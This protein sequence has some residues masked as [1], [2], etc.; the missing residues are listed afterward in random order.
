VQPRCNCGA[1][2][3]EDARFCHKCGKPQYAEDIARLGAH[4]LPPVPPPIAAANPSRIGFGNIRAVGITIAVAACSL[5][6]LW[7]ACVVAPL[8]V[9]IILCGA[10]F[11][12][13]RFYRRRLGEP[14]TPFNGATLGV[15]TGLWLFLMIALLVAITSV[16]IASPESREL[17]K[18]LATKVPD[19]GKMLDDPHQFVVA[20]AEGLIP[21]FFI[22]TIS[23]A[24]GGMLAARLQPR[25]GQSS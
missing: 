14:L 18:A 17:L 5:V 19:I 25:G 9:P 6:G 12:A 2:L 24:F 3:P 10:G 16:W 8:L 11:A 4:D 1:L 23:A 21:V 7:I 15:M 22:L 13:A 20:L